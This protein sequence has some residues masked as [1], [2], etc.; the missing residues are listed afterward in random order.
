M[1]VSVC[2][3]GSN[4]SVF[5]KPENLRPSRDKICIYTHLLKV[6]NQYLP[7]SWCVGATGVII[8]LGVCSTISEHTAPFSDMLHSYYTIPVHLYNFVVLVE[9]CQG[10]FLCFLESLQ[11]LPGMLKDKATVDQ[12]S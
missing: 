4:L 6:K 12:E 2:L 1:L 7:S 10:P 9:G 8:I 11:F 5:S 3:L